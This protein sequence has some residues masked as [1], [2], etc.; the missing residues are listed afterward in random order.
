MHFVPHNITLFSLHSSSVVCA[1]LSHV[2]SSSSHIN[3]PVQI[4]PIGHIFPAVDKYSEKWWSL[5]GG[6][7]GSTP[8]SSHEPR[9]PHALSG[10]GSLLLLLRPSF[11]AHVLSHGKVQGDRPD[12]WGGPA[13]GAPVKG[14]RR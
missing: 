12:P 4:L 3:I 1:L 9:T 8:W 5:D 2:R 14:G 10:A 13:G 11:V 6:E 7:G